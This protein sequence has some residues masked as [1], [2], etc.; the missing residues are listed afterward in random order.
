MGWAI[1]RKGSPSW[2]QNGPKIPLIGLENP[3]IGVWAPKVSTKIILEKVGVIK[4]LK[5]MYFSKMELE[6]EV[7][8]AIPLSVVTLIKKMTS[9]GKRNA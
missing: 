7:C 8:E 4:M 1:I 5:F 6:G 9:R 3:K 2:G